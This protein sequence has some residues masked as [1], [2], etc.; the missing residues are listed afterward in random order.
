[1]V[2][3]GVFRLPVSQKAVLPGA[4]LAQWLPCATFLVKIRI[5][6]DDISAH[7]NFKNLVV[8]EERFHMALLK[9]MLA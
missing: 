3:W 4:L 5:D 8:I 6:V 2:L 1:M 7:A 9:G